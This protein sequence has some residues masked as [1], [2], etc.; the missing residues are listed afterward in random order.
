MTI[1]TASKR[2]GALSF[3]LLR[4]AAMAACIWLVYGHLTGV[5]TEVFTALSGVIGPI[6]MLGAVIVATGLAIWGSILHARL[7]IALATIAYCKTWLHF[8]R[9]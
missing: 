6:A 9:R 2:L 8:E 3:S 4:G 7:L 5:S 1:D